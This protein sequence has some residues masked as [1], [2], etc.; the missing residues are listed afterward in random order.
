MTTYPPPA[1]P[2]IPARWHGGTQTP[3]LIVMHSTVSPSSSGNAR[4]VAH[5]FATEDSPTSAHYIV[6]AGEV[7]QAVHD[8]TVA[9][10][11][12]HNQDSIGIEMCDAGTGSL[13]RWRDADHQAVMG[14][15][16]DLAAQLCLAYD[17]R[18]YY[19][20]A[21][22]LLRGERGITTHAQM[23]KAFRQST[24]TDPGA[25]PRV[26]FLTSVRARMAELR[27]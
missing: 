7:I 27:K 1:P 10:H 16:A 3:R 11:C 17:I 24:H 25:W 18:P 4:K 12:G 8:H 19:V 26:R 6:D 20:D 15:A 5:Y 14:R 21:A 2:Y 23:T 9:Y 13:A 22:A